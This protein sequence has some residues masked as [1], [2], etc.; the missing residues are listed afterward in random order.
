MEDFLKKFKD[1]IFQETLNLEYTHN[2]LADKINYL[3]AINTDD[4][5]R[6]IL[7]K[8]KG[9]N[10]SHNSTTNLDWLKYFPNITELNCNNNNL[11]I[12]SLESLKYVPDLQILFINY[13]NIDDLS[14]LKFTPKLRK[15][16]CRG[17]KIT[18]LSSTDISLIN[19]K[20]LYCSSN[21]IISIDV[22]NYISLTYLDC[23]YNKITKLVL[24][25][26]P[27]LRTL[28]C[29]ENQIINLDLVGH[30]PHNAFKVLHCDTNELTE[31]N[32]QGLINI[33]EVYCFSNKLNL[34]CL[35][36]CKNLTKLNCSTNRLTKL[37]LQ[38]L[39]NLRH[40]YCES[41]QLTN[42][43]NL[44]DA[45]NLK[46]LDCRKNLLNYSY[47]R[48]QNILNVCKHLKLKHFKYD[49]II[50]YSKYQGLDKCYICFDIL[51]SKKQNKVITRCEHI[52]HKVCLTYWM[53]CASTAN[54]PYCRKILK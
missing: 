41:N 43:I 22:S 2:Y 5:L 52:F 32:L 48:L 20:Y 3:E 10:Y 16:Y 46:K 9:L 24:H 51:K 17:N 19:L 42:I 8:I 11:N 38:G 40:L 1:C 21:K 7:L 25:N 39:T 29:R 50:S 23:S 47:N 30:G 27:K 34:L 35:K 12:S 28:C 13:S 37:D 36:D 45:H 54:C 44:S 33:Q 14:N 15:L 53:Y 26:T 6:P 31:L 4:T 18:Q 49:I